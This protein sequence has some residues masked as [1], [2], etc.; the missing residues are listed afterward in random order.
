MRKSNYDLIVG[1]VIFLSLFI[2]IAGV[3]WLKEVSIARK[4]VKYTVLFPNIGTLQVGDPVA[5][6]GVKRGTVYKMYLHKASVAV[7]LNLDKDVVF[8][9]SSTVTIQNIGLMGE[10]QVGIMLSEKGKPYVP[11]TKNHVTYI[12][13]YFDSGIAEA[14]GLLGTVLTEVLALVD[15]VEQII[16]QTVGNTQFIDFFNTIVGR[17]DTIVILVDNLLE[18]NSSQINSAISNV[19]TLTSDLKNL[20]KSNKDNIDTIIG[21]GTQ[22]T[23]S[24]LTIAGRVDSL[25]QSVNMI[26]SEIESGKGSIGALVEDETI[27]R[28]LKK[29]LSDLDSLLQDV[30]DNGLKLRVKLFGNKKYFKQDSVQ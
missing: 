19:H 4:L 17:L 11:D 22:L 5:A 23:S 7:V 9:D 2:L 28:D 21:N 14:M 13:G 30:N 25:V 10:R 3:L 29:S 27:I 8:T 20:L 16:Q 6:N 24:A 18:D 12:N 1:G 26:V 15:T